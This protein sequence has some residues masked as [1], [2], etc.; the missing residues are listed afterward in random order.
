MQIIMLEVQQTVKSLSFVFT[1]PHL[2]ANMHSVLDHTT[3]DNVKRI[4]K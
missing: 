3:W 1:I 2:P 4:F